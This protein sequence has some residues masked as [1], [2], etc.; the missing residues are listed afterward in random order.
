MKAGENKSDVESKL[1]SG[2]PID[3]DD[4]VFSEEEES[5]E[6]VVTLV[7]H[8]DPMAM[9]TGDEQEAKRCAVVPVPRKCAM[10]MDTIGEWEAK[11]TWSP[12]PLVAL[13]VPSPPT[14]DMAEQAGRSEERTGTSA[15]PGAVPARDSQSKDAPPA[16]DTTEQARRFEE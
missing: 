8:R 3:V 4:M 15:S 1:E 2:D 5:R 13:P 11:R 10:S 6:V 7:E 12:C 9:S 16:V 14:T